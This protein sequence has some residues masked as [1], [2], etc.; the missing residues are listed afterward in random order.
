M[1]RKLTALVLGLLFAQLPKMVLGTV[2]GQTQNIVAELFPGFYPYV[3]ETMPAFDLLTAYAMAFVTGFAFWGGTAESWRASG[4]WAA[5]GCV[6]LMAFGG[7]YEH[8]VFLALAILA[9]VAG[10]FHGA[11]WGERNK[12][13]PRVEGVQAFV[14]R[15]NPFRLS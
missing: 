13:D 12:D 10:A 11:G 3:V 6:A 4:A 1:P 8:R 9:R 5:S 15:I 7:A 2:F 14:F